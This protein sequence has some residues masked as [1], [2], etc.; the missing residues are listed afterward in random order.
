MAPTYARNVMRLRCAR[1]WQWK[2]LVAAPGSAQRAIPRAARRSPRRDIAVVAHLGTGARDAPA[3]VMHLHGLHA[4]LCG[5]VPVHQEQEP[6]Q[7]GREPVKQTAV[8]DSFPPSTT[9]QPS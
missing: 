6:F 9:L 8:H 7:D 4:Y 1:T 2:Q 5:R 3:D